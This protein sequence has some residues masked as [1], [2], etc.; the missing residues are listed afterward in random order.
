MSLGALKMHIRTHTLPC[1]VSCVEKPFLGPGYFR[2]T[3]AHTQV[4]SQSIYTV[5]TIVYLLH[6]KD[7][8]CILNFKS[9][10]KM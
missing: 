6:W 4:R 7:V 3:F 9:L 10:K 5:G 8:K 1:S 2:D